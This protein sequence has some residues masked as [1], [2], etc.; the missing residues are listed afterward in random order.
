MYD[1]KRSVVFLLLTVFSSA[2]LAQFDTC[3]N[4]GHFDLYASINPPAAI[5]GKILI[6][7]DLD[8]PLNV[9]T[10]STVVPADFGDFGGGPHKTDDPG[11]RL[12]EGDLIDGELLWFRA[13][14]T[15]RFWDPEQKE[16]GLPLDGERV[17]YYGSAPPD[18][19]FGSDQDLKDFYNAG[20]IWTGDALSGP[21]EAIIDRGQPGGI[22]AHL[23]FCVEA[24]DGDCSIT[25]VG[26]TGNPSRGAYLI[27]FQLF[28][29]A[30]D[31]NKYIDSRP[32]QV[33]LNNGLVD[34]ECGEAITA[35]IEP[36]ATDASEALPGAGILIMT[37]H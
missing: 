10:G 8:F 15:L 18:V 31:G 17:R 27:E 29:D 3:N 5:G 13:L 34:A 21:T 36:A 26:F 20:T 4:F 32:I 23:G 22:H 7:S 2:G 11:W 28:S 33:V 16:W 6:D 25:S 19:V 1:L 35:L 9:N 37:G 14:G 30:S 24:A 12:A